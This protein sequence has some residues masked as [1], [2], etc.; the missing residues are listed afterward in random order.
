MTSDDP[1]IPGYRV[2]RWTGAPPTEQALR[3]FYA[4][5]GLQPYAW[6]NGPHDVYGVHAH[7]YEKVLRVA[8]GS[9]RFDLAEHNSS[10]DLHAGDALVLPAG[11]APHAVLGPGGGP[12]P[13]GHRASPPS[14]RPGQA[15][16]E[17]SGWF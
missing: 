2:N 16:E 14:A 10:L 17:G 1:R 11:G 3:E 12:P 15:T 5:E 13:G 4:R 6:S 8:R 9:I 7:P